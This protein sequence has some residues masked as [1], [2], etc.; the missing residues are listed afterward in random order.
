MKKILNFVLSSL[1][2]IGMAGC[3]AASDVNKT[4]NN[5]DKDAEAA[6]EVVENFYR[7]LD[8]GD[9]KEAAKYISEDSDED[10][11]VDMLNEIEDSMAFDDDTLSAL[12]F[13]GINAEDLK[14]KS[15]AWLGEVL[16]GMF[17]EY[18]ILDVEKIEDGRYQVETTLMMVDDPDAVEFDSDALETSLY[19]VFDDEDLQKLFE[20]DENAAIAKLGTLMISTLDDTFTEMK[21]KAETKQVK[22]SLRAM[23]EKVDDSWKITNTYEV[24][25]SEE[26]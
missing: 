21:K 5:K 22:K 8:K 13:L 15:Y 20:E 19:K 7:A 26:D 24:S 25:I 14:E 10:G 1:M 9:V 18:E 3:S 23:V 4:Q 12:E 17:G 16:G 2:V 11:I 6:A